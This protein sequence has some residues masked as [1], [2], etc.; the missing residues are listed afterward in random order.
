MLLGGDKV[1]R[2][3]GITEK[4]FFLDNLFVLAVVYMSTAL[5][6]TIYLLTNFFQSLPTTFEEAAAI[7]GAGYFTTMIKVMVPMARPS[8]ITVIL[9]NFLAFWNE[10][11]IALTLLP[12]SKKTLP[13]GLMTLMAAS[14]GAAHYGILYSGMVIVMLPTLILYIL[15]QQKLTQGMT[16]GGSKE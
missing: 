16:L 2:Q 3:T 11:I 1:L 8:I 14:K 7:D 10:Y 4:N 12:G 5:P 15:V 9:F 6:F 13:V